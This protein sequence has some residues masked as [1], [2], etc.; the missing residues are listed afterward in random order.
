LHARKVANP[1]Q[2]ARDGQEALDFIDR[3]DTGMPLPAV[4]L[5]DLKLP[6]VSGPEVLRRIKEHPRFRMIPVVILTSSAE[7][8][9]IQNTYHL[10][11]IPNRQ[12]CRFRKVHGSG[13]T[14]QTLQ[15][16]AQPFGLQSVTG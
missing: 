12:A 16:L 11:A 6:K 15:R 7:D 8:V 9:D 2:V 4:I 3:W 1:L 10:G 5:L 14:N 13:R